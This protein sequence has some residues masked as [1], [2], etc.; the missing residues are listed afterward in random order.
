MFQTKVAE[1]IM[2]DILFSVT[3]L[4]VCEIMQENMAE[5]GRPQVAM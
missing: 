2:A 4:S 3:F 1:R 5:R